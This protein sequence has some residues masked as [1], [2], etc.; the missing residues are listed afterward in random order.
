MQEQL[1]N[2]LKEKN[3]DLNDVSYGFHWPPFI[4]ISHLHMHAI[5]PASK[6]RF[7]AR[8]SYMPID[9]W[10]CSVCKSF[11][12]KIQITFNQMQIIVFF[13]IQQPEY[14]CSKLKPAP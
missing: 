2:L 4:S 8:I 9:M 3:V 12:L 13:F 6:M 5:A 1:G 10:Y 7:T 14:V 11:H